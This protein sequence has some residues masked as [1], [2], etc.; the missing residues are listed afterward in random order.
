MPI[1][2]V[3]KMATLKDK[4]IILKEVRKIQDV[5]YKGTPIRLSAEFSAEML[6][7]RREWKDTFKVIKG[8]NPQPRILYTARLLFRFDGE[9]KFYRLA[10]FKGSS[11]TK[12]AL[13]QC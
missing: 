3:I 12:P 10:K 1:H 4:K 11:T 13:Q 5:T 2:I 6:Q 8:Q 7:S 9:I